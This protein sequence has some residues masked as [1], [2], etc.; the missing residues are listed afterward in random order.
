MFIH[1][2]RVW[3]LPAEEKQINNAQHKIFYLS[4]KEALTWLHEKQLDWSIYSKSQHN[5]GKTRR[6]GWLNPRTTT[7][8]LT[9]CHNGGPALGNYSINSM[10][11]AFDT[12]LHCECQ[13]NLAIQ[14]LI[15]C[16][17]S[18]VLR[19]AK[20]KSALWL[21]PPVIVLLYFKTPS[22]LFFFQSEGSVR[23]TYVSNTSNGEHVFS[24]FS[25]LSISRLLLG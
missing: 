25:S 9:T 7:A 19:L 3:A 16:S 10:C 22:V 18:I 1:I 12:V 14:I 24:Q 2:V 5:I 8:A 23:L 6:I 17:L 20:Q 11:N 15:F 4:W 21:R 13:Q